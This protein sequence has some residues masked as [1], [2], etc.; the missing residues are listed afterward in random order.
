MSKPTLRY[1]FVAKFNEDTSWLSQVPP[2]WVKIEF[3]KGGEWASLP[4]VGREAHTF[5][6]AIVTNYEWFK[7]GEEA[8]FCQG[9][10]FDHDRDFIAHLGDPSVRWYGAISGCPSSGEPHMGGALLD[11]YCR[12]LVLPI[13]DDYK[14]VA[15]AQYR[16]TGEQIRSRPLAFYQCLLGLTQLENKSPWS[17]E[18]L[19]PLIWGIELP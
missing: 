19:W 14:F 3:S 15:G 6:H 5:L 16:L 1:L 7:N 12:I 9:N 17:L 18:R 2:G 8:V 4:N 11:E 10:P 13:Q